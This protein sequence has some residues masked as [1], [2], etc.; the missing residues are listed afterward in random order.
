MHFRNTANCGPMMKR[1]ITT[2]ISLWGILL[3]AGSYFI[4]GYELTPGESGSVV[5]NLPD[6]P[7]IDDGDGLP[8]LL[9]FAHPRCPCTTATIRQ[10][11]RLLAECGDGIATTVI[12][13]QPANQ[14]ENWSKTPLWE[15]A[16]QIPSVKVRPD[17]AGQLARQLKVYTSGTAILFDQ[18]GRLIFQGGITASRGHEGDNFGA[19]SIR[20]F[21]QSG[22]SPRRSTPVFGCSLFAHPPEIHTT[23][24]SAES[25]ER[26]AGDQL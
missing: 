16:T 13:L 7:V 20:S 15:A 26:A 25:S 3:I 10:L 11:E 24:R 21:V 12:F 22:G 5:P 8:T 1:S 4:I 18:S 6:H 9:V 14:P 2:L 19:D 23:K 17:F